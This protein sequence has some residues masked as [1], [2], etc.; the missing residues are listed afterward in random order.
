MAEIETTGRYHIDLDY[1]KGSEHPERVF[2]AM[3]HLIEAFERI[4]LHL[5]ESVAAGIEPVI[6][7]EE[8]EAGSVRTWLATAIKSIDDEA[9]KKLDWKQLIG[10][11]LLRGKARILKFLENKKEI[12][13]AAEVEVLEAELVQLA[14]QTQV[15]HIPAYTPIPRRLLLSDLNSVSAAVA[16]LNE[17]ESIVTVLEDEPIHVPR[18]FR[19]SED[20]IDRLLTE[21]TLENETELILKVKKPDYLG[22]S[23]WEFRH[24]GH[25]IEA[26][27]ADA[28]WLTEFRSRLVDL[29][30]G[31]AI[32]V[33]L[34]TVVHY[35]RFGEAVD[36]HREVKEVYE[37]IP[38]PPGQQAELIW[39]EA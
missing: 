33:R 31:D 17:R 14:E 3:A 39:E 25:K 19:I 28:S 22:N 4:D 27:L 38:L 7:L 30:P 1:E 11:Y 6:V 16:P 24:E 13:D 5:A 29:R 8:I 10:T 15:R 2:H 35:D 37:V 20:A 21:R 12:T 26:K 34:L 23:M 18:E 9:L 32:R 36:S